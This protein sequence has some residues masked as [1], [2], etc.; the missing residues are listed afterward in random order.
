MDDL[1]KKELHDLI[2]SYTRKQAIE[3]GVLIDV[4]ELAKEAGF[5]YPV[6]VTVGVWSEWIVPPPNAIGQDTKGRL[7]DL[8]TM[9]RIAA[10]KTEG[11]RVDFQVIFYQGNESL[12]TDFYALIGPGDDIG[13]VITVML[14]WED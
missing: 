13:P 2:F 14:P 6:A 12:V 9:L 10:K 11:D 4:S 3:D 7:W 1:L 8:L 5:K